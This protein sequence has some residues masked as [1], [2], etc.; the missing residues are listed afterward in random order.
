MLLLLLEYD[1][2]VLGEAIFLVG[3]VKENAGSN[4]NPRIS[5]QLEILIIVIFLLQC[6]IVVDDKIQSK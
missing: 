2:D 1:N 6:M 5:A 3:M 4:D